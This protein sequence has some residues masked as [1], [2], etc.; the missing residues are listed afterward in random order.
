M[1]L[2]YKPQ[3]SQT[4]KVIFTK[5]DYGIIQIEFEK[6]CGKHGTDEIIDG[7][8]LSPERLLKILQERDDYDN[9]EL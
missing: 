6:D 7:Y 9:D 4:L 1:S 3:E 2:L 8:I 5:L